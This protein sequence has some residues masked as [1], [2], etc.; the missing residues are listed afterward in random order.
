M[1]F[2]VKMDFTQKARFVAGGHT[3][4]TPVL[5]TYLSVIS[6]DSNQLMVLIAALNDLDIWACDIL[7]A[8]LYAPCREKIWFVGGKDTGKDKG[9]VLVVIWA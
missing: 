4:G 6:R 1:I 5:V 9:K 8:Y 2:A 3:T 7:N